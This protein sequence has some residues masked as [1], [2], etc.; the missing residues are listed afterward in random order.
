MSPQEKLIILEKMGKIPRTHQAMIRHYRGMKI[1][2]LKSR[3]CAA[4]R[5]E[6]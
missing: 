2:Y 5:R 4:L 6:E 3:K 1:H